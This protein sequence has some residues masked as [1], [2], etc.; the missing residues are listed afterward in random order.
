MTEREAG[1]PSPPSF[2]VISGHVGH[3]IDR[4]AEAGWANHCAVGTCQTTLGDVVP[5]RVLEILIQQFLNPIGVKPSDLLRSGGFDPGL[6]LLLCFH[7]RFYRL[8]L[9]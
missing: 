1:V 7:R 5:P 3:I 4:R 6:S 9:S 8:D 2:G